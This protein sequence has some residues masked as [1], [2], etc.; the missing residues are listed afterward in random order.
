MPNLTSLLVEVLWGSSN[1]KPSPA[2]EVQILYI[3]LTALCYWPLVGNRTMSSETCPID[4]RVIW[5]EQQAY[6][7]PRAAMTAAE[8]AQSH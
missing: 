7:D 1:F 6:F 8:H 2:L 4:L 5:L 3:A